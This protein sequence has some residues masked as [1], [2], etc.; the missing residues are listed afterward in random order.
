MSGKEKKRDK[1]R[2][3]NRDKARERD[4]WTRREN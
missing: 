3:K 4:N 2:D 1:N